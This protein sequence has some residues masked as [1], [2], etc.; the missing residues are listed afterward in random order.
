MYNIYI[1]RCTYIYI[2]RGRER[3][4]R[5]RERDQLGGSAR[6]RVFHGLVASFEKHAIRTC[7]RLCSF[8]PHLHRTNKNSTYCHTHATPPTP[9]SGRDTPPPDKDTDT[10]PCTPSIRAS[11]ATTHHLAQRR[12]TAYRPIGRLRTPIG[13]LRT[14]IGLLALC[15]HAFRPNGLVHTHTH[16]CRTSSNAFDTFPTLASPAAKMLSVGVE[17][18][19][20]CI[21][22]VRYSADMLY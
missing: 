17:I 13:R 18:T 9:H 20:G 21:T 10:A 12:R 19:S 1:H 15:L 22:H 5:E 6:R 16:T 8:C 14:H 4:E 3:K 11:C 7:V 2:Y